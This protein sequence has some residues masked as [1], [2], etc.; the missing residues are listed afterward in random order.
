MLVHNATVQGVRELIDRMFVEGRGVAR[1]NERKP[2][3]IS[4]M[5]RTIMTCLNQGGIRITC[6]VVHY[7]RAADKA[8]LCLRFIASCC[9]IVVQCCLRFGPA[10]YA[11]RRPD[12]RF[13]CNKFATNP[14]SASAAELDA[15]QTKNLR[16][17]VADRL[18]CNSI[19]R[20]GTR[21][22]STERTSTQTYMELSVASGTPHIVPSRSPATY[23]RIGYIPGRWS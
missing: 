22:A 7:T 4:Q 5:M 6:A 18:P 12:E 14:H 8:K 19:D 21:W 2:W 1:L 10:V 23:T 16:T 15:A 17:P 13:T 9:C 20:H 3:P 11:A